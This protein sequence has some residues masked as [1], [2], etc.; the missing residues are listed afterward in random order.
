MIEDFPDVRTG[1]MKYSELDQVTITGVLSFVQGGANLTVDNV[2]TLD[3]LVS[4]S[5]L[6]AANLKLTTSATPYRTPKS[7][8]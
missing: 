3:E 1:L 6:L 4:P 5:F 7:G 2:A 8:L